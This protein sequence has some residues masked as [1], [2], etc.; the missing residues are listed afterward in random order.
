MDP[1]VVVVGLP[2]DRRVVGRC[3]RAPYQR[4]CMGRLTEAEREAV[5]RLAGNRTLRE[6][7]AEVGVSHETVR[8]VLRRPVRPSSE[9]GG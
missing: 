6:V 7:A 2:P 4:R 9:L 1:T 5:R 8:A 3:G